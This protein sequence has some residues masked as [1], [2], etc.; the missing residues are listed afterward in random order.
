MKRIFRNLSLFCAAALLLY[1]GIAVGKD[2]DWESINPAVKGATFVNSSKKC[3]E[4]HEEYMRTFA[5][6]KMGM[7]LPNGGCE[8]CHG[9]MSKHLDAPRQE[10][11]LVVSFT[12]TGSLTANQKATVCTSCHL[13]GLQL[14]WQ[15]STHAIEENACTNCHNIMAVADPVRIKATQ[16]EVC[17]RCHKDRRMDSN[18]ISHHPIQEGKVVCSDCHNPHGSSATAMLKKNTVNETCFQCHADKRGPYLW[19]HQPV[20]EKC[21]NC[22]NPH[23]SNI[24]PLLVSRPPFLCD[25][26][27][28]GPHASA[29][30]AGTNVAGWQSGFTGSASETYAGRACLNCH[31]QV[32]G[33]N[34]PAGALLHR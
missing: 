6:T 17:F 10:P 22:H 11:P 15:M 28:D 32:H 19:E 9:P 12:K 1:G 33:S 16:A 26:C 30:P 29:S 3:V 25:E 14:N 4:C 31:S 23:G 34:N 2:V 18:K 21:T 13:G 20:S 7:A 27:H 5:L 24:T 8:S